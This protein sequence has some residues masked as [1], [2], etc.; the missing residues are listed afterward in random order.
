ML[1]YISVFLLLFR[2]VY[3]LLS[4]C[5]CA[6]FS[7]LSL[8]P[9]IVVVYLDVLLFFISPVGFVCLRLCKNGHSYTLPD[10]RQWH[11][12]H[13]QWRVLTMRIQLMLHSFVAAYP[14]N[15]LV[16]DQPR[17]IAMAMATDIYLPTAC[18]WRAFGVM[19]CQRF[20]RR[21]Q[22]RRKAFEIQP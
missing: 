22:R 1:F 8:L 12:R 20:S 13:T 15:F 2:S 5:L 3:C 6:F 21:R 7:S 10:M 14:S 17:E 9:L 4:V 11:N 18:I 16:L 19:H